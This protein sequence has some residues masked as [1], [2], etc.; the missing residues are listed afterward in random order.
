M[1]HPPYSPDSAPNNFSL[2][3]TVKSAL[4]RREFQDIEDI[5]VNVMT[6]LKAILQQEFQNVSDSGNIVGLSA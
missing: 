2:F 3:P 6:A 5:Q 4:K 1:E